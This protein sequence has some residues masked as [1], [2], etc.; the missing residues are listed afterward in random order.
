M[1]KAKE[2]IFMYAIKESSR[3]ID[4]VKVRAFSLGDILHQ[5]GSVCFDTGPFF[6][7]VGAHID[8]AFP[9]EAVL[10]QPGFHVSVRQGKEKLSSNCSVS[11][12]IA[13]TSAI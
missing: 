5:L 10:L 9:A 1:I 3:T 6:L 11:R 2:A 7:H 12:V 13:M 8:D 4:G